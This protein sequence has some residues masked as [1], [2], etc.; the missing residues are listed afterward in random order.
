MQ[1]F[2]KPIRGLL[3]SRY[4]YD[5]DI[6]N[7]HPVILFYICKAHK[8]K[9]PFLKKYVEKREKTLEILY[10]VNP[11]NRKEAKEAYLTCLNGGNKNYN[12]IW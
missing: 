10:S 5:I 11:I 2:Y 6:V 12:R 1:A 9:C 3:A 7:C 4:Y 8:I